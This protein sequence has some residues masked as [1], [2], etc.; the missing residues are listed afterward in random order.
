MKTYEELFGDQHPINQKYYNYSSE[1]YSYADQKEPM[2]EM[3]KKFLD[4]VLKANRTEDKDAPPSLFILDGYLQMISML[5]S[6]NSPIEEI[7][8]NI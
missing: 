5:C 2:L 7:D 3:A 8:A 4:I 6:S 1:L